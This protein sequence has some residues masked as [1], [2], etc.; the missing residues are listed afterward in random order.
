[1]GF[2]P[3][4]GFTKTENQFLNQSSKRAWFVCFRQ[5]N[6][7]YK[8]FVRIRNS[9]SLNHAMNSSYIQKKENIGKTNLKPYIY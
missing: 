1:M 3:A 4:H 6:L 9:F 2:S 7:I 8:Q 5:N